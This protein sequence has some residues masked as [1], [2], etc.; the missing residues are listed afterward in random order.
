[1]RRAVFLDRDGVLNRAYVRDGVSY[2]PGSPAELELLS[3]VAEAVALLAAHNL[4]LAVVTNQ[5]DVARGTQT[6]ATV[7]EINAT[8]RERLPQIDA[9]YTCFHDT[10]DNCACRKPKAGMLVQAADD[11]DIDL[12]GSFMVGDRWSD[13]AAGQAAGCTT[14]LVEEAYSHRERCAPDYAVNSLRAAAQRIVAL[15]A[16]PK[17]ISRRPRMP[18]LRSLRVQI[19]ADGA[20]KAGMLEMARHAHITGFTTNPTLMRKAG[21]AD[22]RAFARDVLASLTDRPISFEVF[23]DDFDEMERQAREIASWGSNVFVKIP[24][25][26]TSGEPAYELVRRLAEARVQLNVTALMTLAQVRDVS[27]AIGGGAPAY[28]SVF[29][30][31]IADTGVDPVPL[32]AAA[33]ELLR[34]YPNQQL[35]WASPRELLNIFQADTIGCHVITVTTDVLKKLGLVGKDLTEYSLE[36]VKMF[37]DDARAAGYTL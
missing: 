18:N 9:V 15:I 28:I 26:N 29:A 13:I 35:I 24:V 21:I 25:T 23:A 33:V 11:H 12:R 34:P 2:P 36:T 8:L 37:Y 19:F 30:G 7:E 32:M 17:E 27:A 22:Y 3:G 14:F 5:P 16:A 6:R 10:P 1:M 31:R 4:L 20:D